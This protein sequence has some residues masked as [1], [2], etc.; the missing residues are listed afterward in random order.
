MADL[1]P[2]ALWVTASH[3]ASRFHIYTK[4]R[5]KD[6]SPRGRS[7]QGCGATLTSQFISLML[8]HGLKWVARLSLRRDPFILF[9]A[10]A[11]RE[12]RRGGCGVRFSTAACTRWWMSADF[13]HLPSERH[14]ASGTLWQSASARQWTSS[15]FWSDTQKK[16]NLAGKSQNQEKKLLFYFTQCD[17]ADS[18][19]TMGF[20]LFLPIK[21]RKVSLI[22]L[23]CWQ[24]GWSSEPT[25][26]NIHCSRKVPEV[27]K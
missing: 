15:A 7:H 6:A 1:R 8:K 23:V 14:Q 19:I 17:S 24:L 9:I 10:S 18:W 12:D 3:K 13:L 2:L 21:N 16:I 25:Y 5:R 11:A 27:C 26:I 4:S 20:E 22:C